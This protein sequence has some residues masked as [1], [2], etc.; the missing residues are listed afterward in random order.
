MDGRL[1]GDRKGR[2]Y[3]SILR[4]GN[5]KGCPYASMILIS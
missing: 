3:A 5:R 4:M 1:T 2:P